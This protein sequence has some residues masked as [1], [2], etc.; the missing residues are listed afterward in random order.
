VSPL[1]K[2][3]LTGKVFFVKNV[4][5]D[6]TTG[7]EI[8]TLPMLV[9]ALR[10]EVDVNL[11]GTSSVKGGRLVNTFAGVQDAPISRFNLRIDGGGNGILVVTR[12]ARGEIDICSGSQVARAIM[13]A[14]NGMRRTF[15]VRMRTP[16][17]RLAARRGAGRR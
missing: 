16:C 11:R 7:R 13:N 17:G 10:G 1:L 3:P 9:V 15:D 2:R 8:R 12:T 14:H 4:R 6:K 5:V